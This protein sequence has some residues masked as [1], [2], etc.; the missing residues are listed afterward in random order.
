MELKQWANT[1]ALCYNTGKDI[2]CKTLLK[3]VSCSDTE[4]MR[5]FRWLA[6]AV[7]KLFRYF[8]RWT[9]NRGLKLKL[10]GSQWASSL[11]SRDAPPSKKKSHRLFIFLLASS[12]LPQQQ[13][14]ERQ[15]G[16]VHIIHPHTQHRHTP[17][18]RYQ[19]PP[20]LHIHTW[21]F[22]NT[23]HKHHYQICWW[24]HHN[25]TELKQWDSMQRRR[26][27]FDKLVPSK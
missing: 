11:I 10:P 15:D 24:Y 26:S 8:A 4:S 16:E 3:T 5:Q 19:A 23:S 22:S 1:L 6:L 14:T 21:L 18:V 27:A 7:P 20:L 2:V 9:C 17:G 25:G 13:T 12:W